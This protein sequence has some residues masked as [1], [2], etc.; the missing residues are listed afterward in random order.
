MLLPEQI[1]CGA[2]GLNITDG[3]GFTVTLKV[4]LVPVQPTPELVK[5]GVTVMRAEIGAAPV[6]VPT[7]EGME[8]LPLAP[9]P[10]AVLLFVHSNVAPVTADEK[11]MTPELEPLQIVRSCGTTAL[12]IGLTVMVNVFEAPAQA[13]PPF[14][15]KYFGI[16][17]IV[18]TKGALVVLVVTNDRISP[19]PLGANPIPV[20]SF[21]Q[22]NVVPV[23]EPVNEMIPVASPLHFTNETGWLTVGIGLTTTVAVFIV[24]LQTCPLLV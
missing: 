9:N 20:L 13:C 4:E 16:T 2:T 18:A 6:L 7:K 23:T 3:A 17:V 5:L 10:M 1:F 14:E 15:F 21:V 8:P 22:L 12:G 24:P 19:L 11:V